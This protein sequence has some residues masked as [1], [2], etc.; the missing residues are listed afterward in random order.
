MHE[1][2][3]MV[4]ERQRGRLRNTRDIIDCDMQ[5]H[6]KIVRQKLAAVR[7]RESKGRTT[8]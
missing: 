7:A 4:A 5:L 1:V 6:V 2:G 8:S 3:A